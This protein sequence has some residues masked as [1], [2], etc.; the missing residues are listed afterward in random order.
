MKRILLISLLFLFGCAN[1]NIDESK[2]EKI[3]LVL[4][5][6]AEKGFAHMGAIEAL[7]DLDYSFDFVYGNSAGS[8]AGAV[9]AKNPKAN[10]KKEFKKL[11]SI[12]I[13]KSKNQAKN[14][15][16]SGGLFGAMLGL[17]PLGIIMFGILGADS[18]K[19]V[20]FDRF[21]YT[22]ST[23]FNG[24]DITSLEIPFGT[25]YWDF[26]NL[27]EYFQFADKGLVGDMV[28]YSCQNPLIFKDYRKKEIDA[29]ADRIA[30]TPILDAYEMFKPTYIIAVNVSGQNAFYTG[31]NCKIDEIV[32][33]AKEVA[34]DCS[35]DEF[36]SCIDNMYTEGY[37][38]VMNYFSDN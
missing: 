18:V 23:Y 15:A 37:N 1:K 17:N 22:L 31:I 26:N 11:L 30:S 29:G 34:R 13:N 35:F 32:V 33:N 20:E 4:S 9:Y 10:M 5:V 36:D 16:F 27:D 19:E 2:Q 8:L 21:Q 24:A 6:G 12:Y 7:R 3:C 14:N 28:S 25:S 38:S